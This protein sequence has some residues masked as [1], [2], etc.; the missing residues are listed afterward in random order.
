MKKFRLLFVVLFTMFFMIPVS[1]FAFPLTVESDG[2]EDVI[3]EVESSDTILAVKEK[4]ENKLGISADKQIILFDG[5]KLEDGRSLADYGVTEDKKLQIGLKTELDKVNIIVDDPIEGEK[6]DYKV[7]VVVS[8]EDGSKKLEIKDLEVKW[9]KLSDDLIDEEEL[10]EDDVFIKGCKY[11]SEF[12]NQDALDE[13]LEKNNYALS[14][15]VSVYLNGNLVRGLN[16]FHIGGIKSI[17]QEVEKLIIGEELPKKLKITFVMEDGEK[18]FEFNSLKWFEVDED[19]RTVGES[20]GIVEAGKRYMIGFDVSNNTEFEKYVSM[21]DVRTKHTFNGKDIPYFMGTDNIYEVIFDANGGTFKN[22]VKTITV[23][24]IINFNYDKFEKPTRD[25]YKFIGFYTEDGKSYLDVM[26]SETGIEEDTT[27]Y[28]KWELEEE[29]PNTFDGVVS[30]L[31]IVIIS[32]IILVGSII[33]F[34]KNN[35]TR[36]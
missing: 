22:N 4:V 29:N 23:E 32:L 26:N 17:N 33:Y 31:S 34:K 10:Q 28:A 7:D 8:N 30:S 25:G 9:L 3:I 21:Q 18:E 35:N 12:I 19:G 14:D 20:S 15:S 5:N 11:V 27:F 36:A 6:P 16:Y 24:D 2:N 13:E 1:V